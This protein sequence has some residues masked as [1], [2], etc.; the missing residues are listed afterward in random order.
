MRIRTDIWLGALRRRV[1]AAGGFATVIAKG[2]PDSGAVLLLLRD[3]SGTLTALSR[4]NMGDGKVSWQPI[5]ENR[6]ERD[7]AAQDALE[8]RRKFD[9]DLWIIELDVD[10]PQRFVDKD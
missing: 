1:E 2:E 6:E 3:S 9:P 10:D 4:V 5:F 8:K 7:P